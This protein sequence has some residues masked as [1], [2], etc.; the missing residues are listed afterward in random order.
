M[1][2]STHP[3][4]KV[5]LIL[6]IS[7]VMVYSCFGKRTRNKICKILLSLISV[8]FKIPVSLLKLSTGK[9]RGR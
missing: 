7:L 1:K 5:M 4:V 2:V 9:K 8:V 6:L 3:G